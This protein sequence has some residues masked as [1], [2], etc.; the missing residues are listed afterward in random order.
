MAGNLGQLVAGHGLP[1]GGG[2]VNNFPA[3]PRS[4]GAIGTAMS[5]QEPDP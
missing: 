5:D 2:E 3:I 4:G 1:P